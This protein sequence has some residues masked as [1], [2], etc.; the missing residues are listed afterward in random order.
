MHR[1]HARADQGI[2]K[3]VERSITP[4]EWL[5][6]GLGLLLTAGVFASIGRE[7]FTQVRGSPVVTVEV[8]ATRHLG[9]K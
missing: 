5:A 2:G 3:A 9:I 4:L 1:P 8:K 6:S 7:A